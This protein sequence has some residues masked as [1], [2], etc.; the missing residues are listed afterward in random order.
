LGKIKAI[1]SLNARERENRAI[2][3]RKRG[4]TLKQIGQ[5][6][7]ISP[8]AV[9]KRIK[10]VMARL[11]KATMDTAAEERY[12]E[13]RALNLMTRAIMPI[14]RDV[15]TPGGERCRAINTMIKIQERRA[16]LLG[17]DRPA[18]YF[19]RDAD[20][21]GKNTKSG[22]MIASELCSTSRI[23]KSLPDSPI[24]VREAS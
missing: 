7:G 24:S 14:I 17:L 12:M 8:V 10:H 16:K 4:L 6:L 11:D 20:A 22:V 21:D 9:H 19:W 5:E 3:L 23:Q 15:N 2:T 13:S 18:G 1:R